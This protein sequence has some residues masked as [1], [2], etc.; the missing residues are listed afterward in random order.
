MAKLLQSHLDYLNFLRFALNLNG[1]I[2]TQPPQR[3]EVQGKVCQ[4]C[5]DKFVNVFTIFTTAVKAGKIM[6]KLNVKVTHF[7]SF[8]R[9]K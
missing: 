3:Q 9:R 6:V 4:W 5:L 2:T 8:R 1:F 7:A